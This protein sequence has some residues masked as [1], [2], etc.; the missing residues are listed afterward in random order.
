MSWDAVLTRLSSVG[1]SPAADTLGKTN[2]LAGLANSAP[3]I[4]V[5]PESKAKKKPF[6]AGVEADI[7]TQPACPEIPVPNNSG[8]RKAI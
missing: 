3:S 6:T 4:K 2:R 5:N 1:E 8:A 7:C